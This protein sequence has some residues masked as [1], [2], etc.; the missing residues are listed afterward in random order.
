MSASHM[1]ASLQHMSLDF[2]IRIHEGNP[3]S[4]C[5][6]GNKTPTLNHNANHKDIVPPV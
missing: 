3:Q 2:M 6:S 1:S 5:T 4:T